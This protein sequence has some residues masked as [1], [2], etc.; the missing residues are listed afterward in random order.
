MIVNRLLQIILIQPYDQDPVS[1]DYLIAAAF[2][3]SPISSPSQKPDNKKRE[4]ENLIIFI[5]FRL[6]AHGRNKEKTGSGAGSESGSVNSW[7][8]STDPE[9]WFG[10]C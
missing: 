4:K 6:E 10:G 3:L 9:H 2:V 8:G 1:T 7:Y 5:F